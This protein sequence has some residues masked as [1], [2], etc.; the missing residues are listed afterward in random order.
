MIKYTVNE[1]A[2][3]YLVRGKKTESEVRNK[4]KKT[5]YSN[6]EINKCIEYMKELNYIDD[7]DY[8][9]KYMLQ[10]ERMKK[11]SIYELKIKLLQK[12]LDK[13]IISKAIE[14]LPDNYEREVVSHLKRVKGN[15]MEEIKFKQYLLKRGFRGGN[16][17]DLYE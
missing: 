15:T 17:D 11:Y 10:N 3:R 4:L 7:N 9:K 16:L 2:V 8:A 5:G 12:G 1:A 14:K 13:D 6:D